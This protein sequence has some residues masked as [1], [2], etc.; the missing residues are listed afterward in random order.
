M[1]HESAKLLNVFGLQ[2]F[3]SMLYIAYLINVVFQHAQALLLFKFSSQFSLKHHRKCFAR[4]KF[5]FVA[6]SVVTLFLQTVH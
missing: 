1:I 6:V 2:I 3:R 5:G 4:H